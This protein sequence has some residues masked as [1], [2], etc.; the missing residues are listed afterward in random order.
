MKAPKPFFFLSW[1]FWVPHRTWYRNVFLWLLYWC[2][3]SF[4]KEIFRIDGFVLCGIDNYHLPCFRYLLLLVPCVSTFDVSSSHHRS[5]NS[6]PG[7][8]SLYYPLLSLVPCSSSLFFF[9]FNTCCY[10]GSLDFKI[11]FVRIDFLRIFT[12]GLFVS[13]L[14]FVGGFV[15]V[16]GCFAF[17]VH[18][19]Q[20]C[21][22]HKWDF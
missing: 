7:S 20:F 11:H 5:V 18:L 15:C 12:L 22:I 10:I 6:F 1:T 14:C 19:S 8:F 3:Y 9:F 4:W 17:D 13:L 16:R 21:S 2:L